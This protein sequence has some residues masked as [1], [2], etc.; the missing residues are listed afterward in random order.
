MARF[1]IV[2]EEVYGISVA[3][4]RAHAKVLGK[5]H[6]LALALWETGSHE[7]RLLAAFVDEPALVTSAQMNVWCKA[8]DNWAVCDTVCLHLFDRSPLAYGKVESWARRKPEF[9]KRAAF[10]LLASLAVHDKRADDARFIP[11]FELMKEAASDERNFVRKAV[12]WALKSIGG[13]SAALHVRAVALARDLASSSKKAARWIG[14]DALRDLTSD[15][16][17]T[18]LQRRSAAPPRKPARKPQAKR[19]PTRKPEARA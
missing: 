13:R 10:A 15:K 8:F 2:S 16:T 3:V 9:E 14:K 7:A 18:R 5:N 17:Q 4:L 19:A 1:G 11:S 6:A 12:S